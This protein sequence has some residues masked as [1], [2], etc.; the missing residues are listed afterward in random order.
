MHV[1]RVLL[2]GASLLLIASTAGADKKK[3]HKKTKPTDKPADGA[4]IEMAP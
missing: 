2:I 1:K 4:E 3:K